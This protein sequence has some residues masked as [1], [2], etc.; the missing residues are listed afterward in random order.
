MSTLNKIDIGP[1]PFETLDDH[2]F[3]KINQEFG[4]RLTQND[5]DR[6]SQMK[7]NP[8]SCNDKIALCKNKASLDTSFELNEINCNYY[9]PDEFREK[10][11]ETYNKNHFSLIHLNIRSIAN[12]FDSFKELLDSLDIKFKIIGLTETWL[13]ECN[14]DNFELL[15]YDYIGSNRTNKKGGGV[16]LYVAK[17]L[18]HKIRKDLKTEIE[19]TIE[20]IFTEISMHTGKNIVIGVIYR[21]PN[22]KMDTFQNAINKILEKIEKENKIC[23]LMGD[24]NID[25]LKSE[26]CEYASLFTEQVLLLHLFL[27]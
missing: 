24:F 25:L 16:G 23:Y 8:I 2:E 7:F 26:S 15:N 17:Q 12:K 18:Q 11:A 20:T 13:K 6:I 27:L 19:D 3:A 22:A 5:M 9:L 4:S 21:P 10:I 14:D 1:M